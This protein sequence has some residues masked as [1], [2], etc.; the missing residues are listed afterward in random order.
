ML[1]GELR[2]T[3]KATVN[4]ANNP[5]GIELID[6]DL[7]VT[8]ITPTVAD[9]GNNTVLLSGT[10]GRNGTNNPIKKAM[11]YC[12]TD[13]SDPSDDSNSGRK[14]LSLTA[15]SGAT[16]SE[17]IGIAKDCTVKAYIKCEF[18]HNTTTASATA[19]AKYYKK[20]GDPGKPVLAD[21]S[22]KNGRLTIKQ[23]WGWSWPL[24]AASNTATHNA[25]KGYRVRLYVNDSNNP[26]VSFY[27][28]EA[29]SHELED[30]DWVY[31][32]PATAGYPMP[33][34]AADQDIV[35][36][37]TV[38]LSVQAYSVNGAGTKLL[39]NIKTSDTYT[40]QNAGIVN[41]KVDG[42]WKEGQVYVKVDGEWKEADT[43]SIKANNEWH[44]SQ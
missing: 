13:G 30:F 5:N 1:V 20:P 18:E 4:N 33:M 21:S 28:G 24:A 37:D 3:G 12:T 29:L 2:S 10:V 8:K 32:R 25:V 39:S 38:R 16:Y 35:P 7:P 40:V 43:V 23:D 9:K 17:S 41:V 22:F 15:T 34:R 36:G 26:I 27:T 19:S 42:S 6:I 44:E 14:P 11:L 31:D